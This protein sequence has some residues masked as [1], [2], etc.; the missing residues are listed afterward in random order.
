MSSNFNNAY[1]SDYPSRISLPIAFTLKQIPYPPLVRNITFYKQDTTNIALKATSKLNNTL[2]WYGTDSSSTSF[3]LTAPIP[4]ISTIGIFH[5]YVSQL[6]N[7]T[8]CE[9]DKANL[10]IT[11][12]PMPDTVN[13]SGTIGVIQ[14]IKKSGEIINIIQD[15]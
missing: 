6:N 10:T 1:Y 8:G 7:E 3:N 12:I 5:Y 4:S 9:S 14:A 11:V 2:K 13:Q 15:H